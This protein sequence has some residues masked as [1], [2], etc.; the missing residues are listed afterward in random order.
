MLL[1]RRKKPVIKISEITFDLEII[2][3]IES[4]NLFGGCEYHYICSHS[5]TYGEGINTSGGSW[6]DTVVVT[7]NSYYGNSSWYSSN[8]IMNGGYSSDWDKANWGNDY[9]NNNYDPW[10]D[11]Y[12]NL[13]SNG[14]GIFDT[15]DLDNNGIDD[16]DQKLVESYPG[17]NLSDAE[18]SWLYSHLIYVPAMINNKNIA[19]TYGQGQHNGV[20]DALR[21]ALWSALDHHD[22]GALNA[23]NFHTLHETANWH[24]VESPS[25]L[26]NN[27]WG[28]NWSMANGNAENNINQFIIDFNAAVANGQI[29]IIP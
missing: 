26:I 4:K 25:D 10:V 29:S 16:A 17:E 12:A 18:K 6:L 13:D 14:D 27:G 3:P 2:N 1:T 9:N 11:P 22:I 8:H 15:D 23:Y 21:H 19:E 24:P 7:N 20:Y 5:S 28:Y